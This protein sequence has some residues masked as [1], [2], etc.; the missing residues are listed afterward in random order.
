M[1]PRLGIIGSGQLALYLC[2]AA[3]KLDVHTCVMS[4]EAEVP[5]AVAADQL[6][7]GALDE[8]ELLDA[9]ID[10]CDV[11]TFDKEDIPV[12]SLERLSEAGQVARL[13]RGANLPRVVG[14]FIRAEFTVA[15]IALVQSGRASCASTRVRTSWR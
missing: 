1:N 7:V 10:S 4:E 12:A 2:Q 11:V 13:K 3:R 8:P 6:L 15:E 9:F 14:S 5:A